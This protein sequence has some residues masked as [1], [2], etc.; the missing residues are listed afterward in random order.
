MAKHL[1]SYFQQHI[2]KYSTYKL[3]LKDNIKN[4]FLAIIEHKVQ[5]Q[6]IAVYH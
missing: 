4:I 2:L 5:P 3:S 1:L 6:A